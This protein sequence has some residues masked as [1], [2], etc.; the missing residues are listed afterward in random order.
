MGK[1]R[2][3]IQ[4]LIIVIIGIL[5]PFTISI[6]INFNLDITNIDNLRK[7][8]STFLWFLLIFGIELIAVYLY[9]QI[10]NKIS[11]KKLENFKH[12]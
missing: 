3:L 11:T 12:K 9:F 10:T 4:I 5:I 2:D 7:I 6:T 1:N 8:G